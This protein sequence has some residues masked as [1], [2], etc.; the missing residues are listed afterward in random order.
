MIDLRELRRK[1]LCGLPINIRSRR[2]AST[3]PPTPRAIDVD[4]QWTMSQNIAPLSSF[5]PTHVEKQ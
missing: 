5:K 2:R 3:A 1:M 4:P